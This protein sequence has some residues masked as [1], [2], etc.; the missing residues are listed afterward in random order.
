MH[1]NAVSPS[2]NTHWIWSHMVDVDDLGYLGSLGIILGYSN[3]NLV[4]SYSFSQ[5]LCSY[6]GSGKTLLIYGKSRLAPEHLRTT[7][8]VTQLPWSLAPLPRRDQTTNK[9]QLLFL[10]SIDANDILAPNFVK[11]PLEEP[12]WK[13]QFCNHQHLSAFAFPDI[14]KLWNQKC[15]NPEFAAV[16]MGPRWSLHANC[17]D[18]LRIPQQLGE[19]WKAPGTVL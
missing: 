16:S 17:S 10:R 19:S 4:I 3:G 7:G 12:D 11:P 1:R 14:L 15:S 5:I 2:F 13:L 6:Q 18:L 8:H 9:L